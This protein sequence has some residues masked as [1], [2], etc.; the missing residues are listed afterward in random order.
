MKKLLLIIGIVCVI[1]CVLFF[2]YAALNLFGYHNVLDGSPELY[3]RMHHR[4]TVYFTAGVVLAV[5]GAAIFI[6]RSKI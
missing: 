1:V 6:I 3:R 5:I 2:L 4:M